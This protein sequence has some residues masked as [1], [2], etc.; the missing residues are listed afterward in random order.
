MTVWAGSDATTSVADPGPDATTG[1][2]YAGAGVSID[3]G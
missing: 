1:E 3:A 2:T